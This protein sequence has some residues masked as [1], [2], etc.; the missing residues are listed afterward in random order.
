MFWILQGVWVTNVIRSQR[1]IPECV[2]A[3]VASLGMN[4]QQSSMVPGLHVE[5]TTPLFRYLGPSQFEQ[6]LQ[7]SYGIVLVSLQ[8]TA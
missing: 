3:H 7:G 2:P 4:A 1:R 8:D 5:Q 6:L